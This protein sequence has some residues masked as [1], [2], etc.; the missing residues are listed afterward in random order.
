M[1]FTI[2]MPVVGCLAFIFWQ[3]LMFACVLKR[4]RHCFTSAVIACK[5]ASVGLVTAPATVC[6]AIMI[7]YLEICYFSSMQHQIH[8][9]IWPH[10]NW[11]YNVATEWANILQHIILSLSQLSLKLGPMWMCFLTTFEVSVIWKCFCS[12]W[13]HGS[14]LES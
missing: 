2:I 11:L 6:S 7:C 12:L 14:N 4:P 10:C 3:M 8:Q 5:D 1:F 13:T 9:T